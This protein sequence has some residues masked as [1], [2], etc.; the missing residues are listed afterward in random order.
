MLVVVEYV[1]SVA[2]IARNI[3]WAQSL[4]HRDTSVPL[5]FLPGLIRFCGIEEI[6]HRRSN[7]TGSAAIGYSNGSEEH[8]IEP[9]IVFD[10]REREPNFSSEMRSTRLNRGTC[11]PVDIGDFGLSARRGKSGTQSAHS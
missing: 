2:Q 10:D 9:Q 4:N 5:R 3:S 1:K 8:P 6:F 11:L 7:P